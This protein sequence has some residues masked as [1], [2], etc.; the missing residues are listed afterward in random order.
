[1]VGRNWDEVFA[2]VP[3]HDFDGAGHGE[4]STILALFLH[5]ENVWRGEPRCL[6]VQS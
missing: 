5:G 6:L 3:L 4:L 1:V 2:L